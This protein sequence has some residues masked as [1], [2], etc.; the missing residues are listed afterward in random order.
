[1]SNHVLPEHTRK[2]PPVLVTVVT[3]LVIPV[4]VQI[5]IVVILVTQTI[6]IEILVSQLAQM[7]NTKTQK[8]T[9]VKIVCHNVP[10]AQT[11]MNVPPV[12]MM[13]MMESMT[14]IFTTKIVLYAQIDS[15]ETTLGEY[16]KNVTTLVKIV[17]EH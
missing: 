11:P 6:S 17:L 3:L 15:M 7:E 10:L 5:V 4:A 9:L 12:E 14:Y 13:T 16:V 8:P 1:M 2:P